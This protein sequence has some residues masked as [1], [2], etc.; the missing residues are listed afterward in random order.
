MD[1]SE[2]AIST[3]TRWV[4]LQLVLSAVVLSLLIADSNPTLMLATLQRCSVPLL[5]FALIL[6]TITLG[7]HEF[8]LWLALNKPRPSIWRTMEV[9]FASGAINLVFPA[10][11]GDV[12]AI[13]MLRRRCKLSS[14]VAAYAIGMASFFE[15]AVF[16]LMMLGILTWNSELWRQVLGENL[17]LQAFQSVT[18]L[19]LGGTVIVVIAALIG[20]RISSEPQETESGFS[21]KRLLSDGLRETNT[22]LQRPSYLLLNIA[23]AAFE[24]W[25]MIASFAL[26][27]SALGIE[28]PAPWMMS[29]IILGLSALS[30]LVLPPT[31]GA[32]PA[33][34]AVFVF[35]LFG[36]SS[37]D[38][39]AYSSLWWI[40]S[41]LPA[42]SLG[43]PA[44]MRIR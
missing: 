6:K 36:V 23:V 13:A 34:A 33:A 14:G 12:A 20:G 10:R 41:Q 9:G 30:S 27:S 3:G 43:I 39:L 5:V 8:R 4:V 35:A 19:T 37:E 7:L 1:V 22:G 38:A 25:M 40:I 26:A 21:F 17:H 29:G 32:G 28:L 15:A 16:G 2:Q 31:Y 24:V 44:I 18:F 11:A 42:A